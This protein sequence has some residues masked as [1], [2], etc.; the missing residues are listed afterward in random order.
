M[1]D[2]FVPCLSVY[3]DF[4]R[5]QLR[6]LQKRN[7]EVDPI[8]AQCGSNTYR[9]AATRDN[10]GKNEQTV[11]E[12][13]K[14]NMQE[15]TIPD[16]LL[17]GPVPSEDSTSSE[18]VEDK[19]P[20]PPAKPFRLY[21]LP[22]ELR[23]RIFEFALAPE[24]ALRLTS[25][26]TNRFAVLP[27]VS[28]ALLRA[29]KQTEREA[30]GILFEQNTIHLNV[31]VHETAWPI[32]SENRLPMPVLAQLR[33]LFVVLDATSYFRANYQDVDF[34]AFEAMTSLQTLRICMLSRQHIVSGHS[35]LLQELFREILER[36]PRECRIEC[37]T[38]GLLEEAFV[39]ER[40]KMARQRAYG[41]V[42]Y[43]TDEEVLSAAVEDVAETQ[44]CKN[45]GNE[46]VFADGN[47]W[48]NPLLN[49]RV[50]F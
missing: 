16:A 11:N 25:N 48:W 47:S 20:E 19:T 4:R 43:E 13:E 8:M 42:V 35:L 6:P 34:R 21:D 27:Q 37:G 17:S 49:K 40:A 12:P 29:S 50:T 15:K 38:S 46:D 22:A 10:S 9:R 14:A 31:D 30:A 18:P 26:K 2:R 36:V 7:L 1:P 45:G 5:D 41:V 44:G 33:H 3:S 28:P 39:Q 23:M 32:I 24:L